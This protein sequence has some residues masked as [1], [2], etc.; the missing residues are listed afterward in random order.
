MRTASRTRDEATFLARQDKRLHSLEQV[1]H[2]HTDG[3]GDGGGGDAVDEVY[4]GAG[5]PNDPTGLDP[6]L[7]LWYDPDAEAELLPGPQGPEGPAGP[8]GATGPAGPTGPQ[9]ATGSTGPA[10]VKGDTGATGSQGPPGPTGSQG[11]A[12]PQGATGTGITMRGSVATVGALP[13]SGNTQGDAFLVQADDSL[14]IWD[15]T[16]WV[17]GGSIQGPPGPQGS[18]GAQGAVG[19]EG[20][21]GPEGDA[22]PQGV[23]GPAGAQGPQGEVGPAGAAGAQGPKGDTGDT[24]AAGPQGE[25]GPAEVFVGETE[26]TD[27]TVL[28][29]YNPVAA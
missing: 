29:W 17:S 28:L 22:G 9:G 7:E 14:H 6:T 5:P 13:P 25:V 15:G 12:G 8:Q 20:P 3:G 2:R 19:P 11:P 4:V 1:A 23:A 26:P 27:P 10:G 21:A 24:G 18:M 16:A